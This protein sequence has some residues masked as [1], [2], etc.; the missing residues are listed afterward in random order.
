MAGGAGRPDNAS[1]EATFRRFVLRSP[2]GLSVA[3][4]VACSVGLSVAALFAVTALS[5]L[6]FTERFPLYVGIAVV[7]PLL[8]ATP[9]SWII[10]RLVHEAEDARRGAQ[11][12]AWSD[13]LTGLL[14]RRRFAELARRE[15]D[16]AHRSGR[17][18]CA[19]LID[20]DDFKRINDAHG[21]GVGDAVLRVM[22]GGLQSGLRG[23]DLAGRWGGEEFA[24]LLPDTTA[25]A[26]LDVMHRL[27]AALRELRVEAGPAARAGC[28]ASIGVAMWSGPAERFEALFGRADA[29]MYAAKAA[30]KDRI[31]LAPDPPAP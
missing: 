29:A 10:V 1:M 7:C 16:I 27:R 31:E 8:V 3:F 24:L 20:L 17:R 22:A 6:G 11:A 5:G 4:V 25:E 15:I 23:S 9:V 13:E 18:P 30:G 26:A 21:H 19:V 2:P 12:L 28:T 14:S